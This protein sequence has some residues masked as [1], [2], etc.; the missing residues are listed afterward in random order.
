MSEGGDGDE[1]RR[2]KESLENFGGQV[3]KLAHTGV[4]WVYWMSGAARHDPQLAKAIERGYVKGLSSKLG[5]HAWG[6]GSKRKKRDGED[7]PS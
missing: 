7:L 4:R 3:K 6:A 5:Y 1:A 2:L